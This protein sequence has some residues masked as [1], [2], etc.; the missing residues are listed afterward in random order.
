MDFNFNTDH[1]TTIQLIFFATIIVGLWHSE[2]FFNPESL[3][4]KWNHTRLNLWFIAT[5]V[6]I[7]L[8]LTIILIKVMGWT[9]RNDWGIMYHI[10]FTATFIG[11]LIIG[12]LMLDFFEYV[13]HRMMHKTKYLWHFHLVHHSDMQL[14]V[15]T[16]VREH[17]AETFIR[18]CTM[19]FVMYIT[20]VTLPVLIIR[21]FI[22]SLFNISSHTSFSLPRN[23][24][25]VL[26]LVF[27]TPGVHKVHHHYKLPYTDCNYGD[28]LSIWDRLF[29]TYAAL[30]NSEIVYGLDVTNHL[31]MGQF[32]ELLA[33]PFELKKTAALVDQENKEIGAT[34]LQVKLKLQE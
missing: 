4:S 25:R 21:Q 19:I 28:V 9:A 23:L 14:D 13:Y 10:P 8:P 15:S 29:G 18:V 32:N 11:K 34:T 27:V 3:K 1:A 12:F 33:Y 17:P 31:Q 26:A 20:G 30:H 24:E 22:Q 7:Q 6:M 5:A 2:L 16:T